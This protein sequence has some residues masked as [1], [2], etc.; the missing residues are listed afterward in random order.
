MAADPSSEA[1]QPV[2]D[3]DWS[4]AR[5]RAF[6]ERTLDL[7]ERFL[8]ELPS[9]PVAGSWTADEVARAVA[10]PVP[11]EPLTDDELFAYLRDVAFDWSM[12]PGHPR[13]MAYITGT[14]TVPGAGCTV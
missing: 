8:T 1:P 12:Y 13:F 6:G 11:E 2:A 14:G 7:W 10:R 3:L 9:L 5:A 4:P